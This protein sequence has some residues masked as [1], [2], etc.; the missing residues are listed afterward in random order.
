VSPHRPIATGS[1]SH[2]LLVHDGDH[3]L[4]EG[5]RAF[6]DQGL[7]SGGHVLVHSAPERVAMLRTVLGT[8][9]RLEYGL[10]S[11]LYLTPMSTL[12]A[13]QRKLAESP[14]STEFWVTGTVPLGE[15]PAGHAAWARYESAV[16][17]VLSPYAFHGLCTYD[18]RALPPETIA[19]AR[20]THPCVS[21]GAHRT[22]SPEYQHPADFLTNPAA[23]VP[24]PPDS[25]PTLSATL[26]SEQDLRSARHLVAQSAVASS[27]VARHVID[28]FVQA[29]NEALV[30]ALQH[31]GATVHL[32]AWAET[33][34]LTCLVTDAGSGIADPLS[35]YAYPEAVGPRGLWVARQLCEGLFISNESP[36]GCRVLLTTAEG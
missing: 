32:K 7:A 26:R 14:A 21:T 4:V 3:D 9:P 23:G 35:G 27:A 6:V 30:N 12:F 22:A 5:T 2:D 34:R 1:Y 10:D 24:G 13:Y 29:V 25:A 36:A 28:A 16:N 31:G 8:H 17:E 15:N 11:D 19:A 33:S 18:L 20:A